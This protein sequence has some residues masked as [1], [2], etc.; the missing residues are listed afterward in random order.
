[1]PYSITTKDGITLQGIPDDVPADAPELKQRVQ[2]IRQQMQAG[3]APGG[4]APK[5]AGDAS[6]GG[7]MGGYLQGVRDPIDAGAQILRHLVPDAVGNAVDNLG[8]KLADLGLPVARSNGAAGVDKLVTDQNRQYEADR[9]AAG[10]GDGTDWMRITGNV[11]NPATLAAAVETGGVSTLGQLALA[12]ARAGAI[13]GALQPVVGAEPG[14]FWSEKAGQAALGA[15]TGAVATPVLGKATEAAAKGIKTVAQRVATPPGVNVEV[16]VNNVL[17]QAPTEGMDAAQLPKVVL[18]SVRRQVGEALQAKQALQPAAILRK[19]QAEAVGLTGDAAPTLGQVTRDPIQFA[20]EKN[21]SGVALNTG[22]GQGNPLSDRFQAQAKALQGVFDLAGAREATDRVT[23][24]QT[25]IDALKAYDVPIKAGVDGAYENA[26]AMAQGRLAELERGHF[27][28]T[29]NEALDRGMWGRFVPPEVRGLL[30]DIT[31]GKVPFN[32]ESE[33]Q[34]DGILSAAQRKAERSGDD[35]TRS[36]LGVIRDALR[37]TPLAAA[38]A[39]PPGGGATAG[40]ARAAGDYVDNGVTD[41]A[42]REIRP[43]A[44]PSSQQALPGPQ[45]RALAP[46]F[47]FP[48]PP[49][50]QGGA[51]VPAGA[52]GAA[53]AADEGALAREAFAQARRAARSRFATIEQVPALKAALDE[54]APDKF[55]QQFILGADARDVQALRNVLTSSPEALAQARAQIADHLKRAAFGPNLSGDGGFAA[56]RYARTLQALG[57]QKLEAFFSPEELVRLNLVGKVASDLNSAPA[58]AKFAVNYSGTGAAVMNLLSKLSEAPLLRR[59]PGG[60]M[61]ANEVGGISTEMQINRALSAQPPRAPGPELSPEQQ[62][63]LSRLFP[64]LGGAAGAAAARPS[65]P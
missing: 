26:R 9:K 32:V 41:A 33:V 4:E 54:A 23:G 27:S 24:G 17:R 45:S 31:E 22:R 25:I 47:E 36:A 37:G 15:A 19:A 16:A 11:I 51:L 52:Q 34:I 56:D 12:G 57:K 10:R 55:V 3:G 63:A 64:L 8:N 38:E 21:L 61:L 5:P 42:F 2:A 50:T 48:L 1:M 30:N 53:A 39:A 62:R 18:D 13:S 49:P 58:G 35:A 60:R 29:A 28:R 40:A 14:S 59:I 43:Q 46:D 44:L 20:Q 6:R 7:K 65:L